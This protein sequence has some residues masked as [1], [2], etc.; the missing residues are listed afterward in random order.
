M[1]P[2]RELD[3]RVSDNDV[4]RQPEPGLEVGLDICPQLWNEAFKLFG[5]RMGQRRSLFLEGLDLAEHETPPIDLSVEGL[6][7]ITSDWSMKLMMRVSP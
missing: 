2:I 7:L 1:D 4:L 3:R 6:F 5:Y